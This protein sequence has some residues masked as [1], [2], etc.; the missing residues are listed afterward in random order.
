[1]ITKPC[2]SSCINFQL[3]WSVTDWHHANHSIG[4]LCLWLWL[5]GES[6]FT[7]SMRLLCYPVHDSPFISFWFSSFGEASLSFPSLNCFSGGKP[8]SS[9]FAIPSISL[10]SSDWCII[11]CPIC[12]SRSIGWISHVLLK[13]I[14][15]QTWETVTLAAGTSYETIKKVASGLIVKQ[16]CPYAPH[17]R[18]EKGFCS[19]QN[20]YQVTWHITEPKVFHFSYLTIP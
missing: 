8:P 15:H 1:M 3:S 12:R 13:L 18:L 6:K 2:F 7:V 14:A 9:L 4:K 16:Q 5:W 20:E 19:L 17:H 10:G 11:N